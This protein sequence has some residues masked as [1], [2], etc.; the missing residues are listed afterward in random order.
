MG[1]IWPVI[2]CGGSGT[3][4]WPLSR[5]SY[6]KQ[7]HPLIGDDTLFQTTL[8]RAAGEGFEKP[9]ILTNETFRFQV[10]EQSR[11]LSVDMPEIILEPVGRNTAPAATVAALRVAQQDPEGLVLLMPSDHVI[12]DVPAF[13]AA[14]QRGQAAAQQGSI[15]TFGITPTAPETGYGYIKAGAELADGVKVADKF[16]EKPDLA[17]AETMLKDGGFTW[18][19]GIFL[20]AAKTMIEEVG[21]LAPDMLAACEKALAGAQADLDFLRLDKDSFAAS[22][23]QSVDYAVM[24]HTDRKAVVPT[25]CGWSDVGS[26]Q[27]LWDIADRDDAGNVVDGDCI[28]L[29]TENSLVKSH[30]GQTVVTLGMKDVVVVS[31]DD[32]VLVAPRE[33]SQDVKKIVAELGARGRK[34]HLANTFESR[35]WGSFHQLNQG[36]RHQVKRITVRPGGRLSL[37]MHHHRAE[38]WI[39]VRGTAEVTKGED[40]FL[41]F[42]NESV[43]IPQGTKHRL[44]NTGVIDLDLIEVQSG[45]YLGEDDIVRFEDVYNRD[46]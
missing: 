16:V 38:H 8:K 29:E 37:Q 30:L 41:L 14:V 28:L 45:S 36:V 35:P 20:Y 4:L 9:T 15:V 25:S 31:S 27:A 19:S 10:A 22:P 26:W 13:L 42:E 33:R 18:N 11:A 23:S 44:A 2:L 7:F 40:T 32:A 1:S 21:R 43:Y 3:R 17:T 34:E 39:V 12:R 5:E 46:S 6:P 24:E